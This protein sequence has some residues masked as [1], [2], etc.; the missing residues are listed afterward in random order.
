MKKVA[1]MTKN[2][3]LIEAVT[4][5]LSEMPAI[6]IQLLSLSRYER[7]YED[8]M[9][10]GAEYLLVDATGTQSAEGTVLL[11]E[12]IQQ[13]IPNGHKT[14]IFVCEEQIGTAEIRNNR[15]AECIVTNAVVEDLID[16]LYQLE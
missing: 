2:K 13:K 3:Q 12:E 14:C 15:V 1:L 8:I 4:A 5:K 10:F 6:N 16:K 9:E 7:A 11:C